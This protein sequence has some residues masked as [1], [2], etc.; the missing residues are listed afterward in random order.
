MA[1]FQNLQS[2]KNLVGRHA[3]MHISCTVQAAKARPHTLCQKKNLSAECCKKSALAKLHLMA[4]VE[5]R[6]L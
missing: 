1:K 6:L 4:D 3:L 2:L 5:L